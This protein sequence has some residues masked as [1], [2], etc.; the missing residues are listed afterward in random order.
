MQDRDREAF[1]AAINTLCGTFRVEA[2]EALLDGYWLALEDVEAGAVKAAVG[3][4]LR[5][6]ERMPAPADLRKLIGESGAVAA[7]DAWDAVVR[8]IRS[9]GSH[10][11]VDFGLVVNATVRNLGGWRQICMTDS[12]ELHSFVRKRF[13]ETFT[14]MSQRP[15]E[16]LSGA[17]LAG[18]LDPTPVR[19]AI[20]QAKKAPMLDGSGRRLITEAL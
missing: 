1:L 7:M 16:H 15:A 9:L 14:A 8:A 19:V 11:T 3:R 4:A 13:E 6:C 10:R 2:T 5:T 18:E 12:D 17:P 20:G